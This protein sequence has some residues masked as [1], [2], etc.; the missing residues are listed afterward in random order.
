MQESH[1]KFEEAIKSEASQRLYKHHLDSFL[2][3][4]KIR[5]QD[6]LLQLKDQFHKLWR[7]S[8]HN[9]WINCLFSDTAYP[10]HL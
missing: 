5:D 7:R 6:G 10:V 8:Y 2:E 4:T 9:E 3:F 1:L